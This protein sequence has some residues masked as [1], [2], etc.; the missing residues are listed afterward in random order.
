MA[1]TQFD[2]TLLIDQRRVWQLFSGKIL[3]N[4]PRKISYDFRRYWITVSAATGA[5]FTNKREHFVSRSRAPYPKHVFF[6]STHGS[7]LSHGV[8]VAQLA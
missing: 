6:H 2:L 8:E 7:A 4:I 1:G 5:K 3:G